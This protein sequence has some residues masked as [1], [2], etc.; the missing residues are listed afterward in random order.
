MLKETNYIVCPFKDALG[1]PSN[2]ECCFK[3]KAVYEIIGNN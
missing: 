2:G 3:V 1:G